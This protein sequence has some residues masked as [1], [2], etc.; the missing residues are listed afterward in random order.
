M[1]FQGTSYRNVEPWVKF[2]CPLRAR[3]VPN[4]RRRMSMHPFRALELVG[5]VETRFGL[6]GNELPSNS[7]FDFRLKISEP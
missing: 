4:A 5:R 3:R 6:R 7:L 2:S 1:P